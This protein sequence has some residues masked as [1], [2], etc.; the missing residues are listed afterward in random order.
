MYGRDVT[1]LIEFVIPTLQ[2]QLPEIDQQ[3]DLLKRIQRLTGKVNED[4]LAVQDRIHIEQQRQKELHDSSLK[5]VKFKIGEFVLLYK[6]YLRGKQKLEERWK[7]P[8]RIHEILG[9]GAYKIRTLDERILKTP[10]NSERLKRYHQRHL[11]DQQ[12]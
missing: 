9:N 11:D 5:E 7:G 2:A 10:V 8:Y 1:L 4:R 6:S 3:E 12:Q